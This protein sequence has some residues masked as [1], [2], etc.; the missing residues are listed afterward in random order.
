M[1]EPGR[2]VV[3]GVDNQETATFRSPGAKE[4]A[5]DILAWANTWNDNPRPFIWHKTPDQ[6]LQRLVEY[7]S[8]INQ[9]EPA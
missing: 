4:L 1:D 5:T 2:T 8:T 9:K 6:I 7:C 3:L